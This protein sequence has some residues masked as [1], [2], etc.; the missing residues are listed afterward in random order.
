MSGLQLD[1]ATTADQRHD[2][3]I[4][5][6]KR[7]ADEHIAQAWRHQMFRLVRRV[8][9]T[10]RQ[11]SDEG[12]FLFN[13]MAENYIEA[14]LMLVRRELDLA[15]KTE[16]LR[17]LLEDIV[18]HPDVLTRARYLASWGGQDA[19]QASRSFSIFALVKNGTP[20]EDHIDP[21]AVK[22]D[23]EKAAEDGERVRVFA[24]RTRAHRQKE[25][26]LD[27]TLTF[28]DLHGAIADLREVIAK[29]Y[30]LLTQASIHSWE[31]TA[32]YDTVT[33]FLK[34]WVTDRRTLAAAEDEGA[35]YNSNP[36]GA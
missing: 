11:L 33:P 18:E 9:N 21:V 20:S 10:N 14:A 13:W 6:V 19:E 31:L 22:A 5:V 17:H 27:K 7:I 29:Y 2:A 24:E 4:R 12:G 32:Q 1:R 15:S 36:A 30:L 16:N 3:W 23:L 26:G 25:K 34:P 8:F 35:G 28:R